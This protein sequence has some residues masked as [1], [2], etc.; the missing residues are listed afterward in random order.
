[1][2]T[3]EW[4]IL[5]K[6]KNIKCKYCG[7]PFHADWSRYDSENDEYIVSS[8]NNEGSINSN[9]NLVFNDKDKLDNAYILYKGKW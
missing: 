3:D 4:L 6:S 8:P 7:T 5:E 1:M 2:R 9:L